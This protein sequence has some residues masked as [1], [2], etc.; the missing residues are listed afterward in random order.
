MA[1]NEF[2]FCALCCMYIQIYLTGRNSAIIS[3]ER[4]N[5]TVSEASGFVEVCV[6]LEG[7]GV[8]ED[9]ITVDIVTES[10]SAIGKPTLR[11][12]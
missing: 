7:L 8:E 6:N 3:L 2:K 5:Y 10:I 12:H 11:D 9:A 4:T 1:W